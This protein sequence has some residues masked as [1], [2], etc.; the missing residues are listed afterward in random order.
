M[1]VSDGI[2]NETFDI[3]PAAE[4]Q[5]GFSMDYKWFAIGFTPKFLITSNGQ[6][7][8]NNSSSYTASLNFFY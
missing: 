7:E 5:I 1:E 3:R 4:Y 2:T 6:A 8:L